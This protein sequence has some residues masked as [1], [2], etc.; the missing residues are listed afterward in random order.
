MNH[1]SL[2]LVDL[3][4]EDVLGH[5]H[6]LFSSL[7]FTSNQNFSLVK[8]DGVRCTMFHVTQG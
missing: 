6:A 7:A 8:I 3:L 4:H 2:D 5:S 1:H